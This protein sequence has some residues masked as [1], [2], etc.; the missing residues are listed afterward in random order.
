MVRLIHTKW[1]GIVSQLG[2]AIIASRFA[3]ANTAHASSTALRRNQ[4]VAGMPNRLD[5]GVGTELLTQSADAHVDDVRPWVERVA[6]D[7]GEQSLAAD[8]LA[9]VE[10]QLVQK[11]ELAIGQIVTTSPIRACRRARSSTTQPARTECSSSGGRESRSCTR[12]RANSSS[13]ENGF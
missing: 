8:H 11:A 5:G 4:P 12:M 3:R 1:K 9:C 10:E 2:H 6:P 13:S 7:L